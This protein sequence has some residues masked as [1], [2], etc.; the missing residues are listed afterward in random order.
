MVAII[1]VPNLAAASTVKYDDKKEDPYGIGQ[2]AGEAAL[3]ANVAGATDIG[4]AAGNVIAGILAFIGVIFFALVLYAG[5]LWMTARGDTSKIDKAKD[6]LEDAVIGVVL[7]SAAYAIA[8]F[9][10][11]TVVGGGQCAAVGGVCM[12]QTKCTA[13]GGRTYTKNDAANFTDESVG[14]PNPEGNESAGIC[15]GSVSN[16]C[17]IK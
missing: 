9:V 8:N 12:D 15:P 2:T 11:G 4:G 5:M 3:P 10:F 7:V 14:P 17:C 13:S 1:L 6:I 16:I